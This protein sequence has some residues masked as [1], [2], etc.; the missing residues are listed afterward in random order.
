M[1]DAIGPSGA[2]PTTGH[3]L[4]ELRRAWRRLEAERDAIARQLKECREENTDLRESASFWRSLYDRLVIRANEL[5]IDGVAR[6]DVD[7]P[8]IAPATASTGPL[9][10]L[11]RRP[12]DASAS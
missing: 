10:I 5:A 9:A 4:E 12:P 1:H 6:R 3:Q 8:T 7:S 2:T 11:M